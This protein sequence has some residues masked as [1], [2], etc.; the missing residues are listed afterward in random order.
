MQRADIPHNNPLL[1]SLTFPPFD[2]IQP[3]HVVPALRQVLGE[4]ETTLDR[5]E[6]RLQPTWE[7]LVEPLERIYDRLTVSWGVVGHLM[8]VKNSEA[9]RQAYQEVQPAVVEF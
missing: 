2:R 9:L 7:G 4:L 3:E 5:L 6:R 1:Q 8:G